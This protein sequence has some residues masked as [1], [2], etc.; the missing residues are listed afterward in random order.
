MIT[1]RTIRLGGCIFLG[2]VCFAQEPSPRL[3][4]AD[5][6]NMVNCEILSSVPV[7]RLKFNIVDPKGLPAPVQL[8]PPDRLAR[9]L[10]IRVNERV[11]TPFYAAALGATSDKRNRVTMMLVDISGSMNARLSTGQTRFEAAKTAIELSLAKFEEG[12]DQIAIVPFESHDVASQILRSRFAKTRAEALDQVRSLPFPIAK[13]NTALFSAVTDGLEVL[14]K[15]A[16]AAQSGVP[17]ET[18]LVLMTD[19]KNEILPGDDPGLLAGPAGLDLA[20]SRVK[21]SNAEVVG[22]GFGDPSQIDETALDRISTKHFMA[23][24]QA[25]LNEIFDFARVL[26]NSRILASFISPW[27]DRATLASMTLHISADLKIPSGATLLSS[28]TTWSTP[29]MGIPAFEGSCALEETRALMDQDNVKG[30]NW[31]SVIR[32]ALV[33]IGIGSLILILWFWVPRLVWSDQYIGITPTK[34][35]WRNG[36][37]DTVKTGPNGFGLTKGAARAPR[38]PSDATIIQPRTDF[39]KTRLDRK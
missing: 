33:F 23:Q 26:L 16:Q 20:A 11:V 4:F 39:S 35:R 32:P 36:G 13:N 19:G 38:A 6:V 27:P 22:V 10:S 5:K 25:K 34:Q 7:F 14:A 2:A 18:M 9:S 12:V 24:D 17:A 30:S 15:Y 37:R 31:I 29:Q 28:E 1:R 21:S 3:E 8:P